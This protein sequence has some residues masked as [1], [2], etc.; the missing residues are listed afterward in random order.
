MSLPSGASVAASLHGEVVDF[1][2]GEPIPRATIRVLG[3]NEAMLSNDSG[4]FKLRLDPGEHQIK[5]SHVAYY[6]E[7]VTV[8]SADSVTGYTIALRPALIEV[9]GTR[10][11]D[12]EVDPAGAI[13]LEAIRRKKDLLSQLDSYSF[14]AYTKLVVWRTTTET[15]VDS[16]G[17]ERTEDSSRIILLAET[18]ATSWWKQPDKF[19]QEIIAR[20]QSANLEAEQNFATVR[21]ILNFNANRIDILRYS[22]PTPTATDALD[23][24]NYYLLDTVMID[25]M[26]AF[27]L[28]V[29]PRDPVRPRFAGTIDIADSSYAVVGVDLGFSDGVDIQYL[30]DAGYRQRMAL[31]ENA[32]WMPVEVQFYGHV[33]ITAPLFGE[34][35][36]DIKQEALI[37][38]YRF[39]PELPD[40]LFDEFVLEVDA[41]ADDADSAR[42][43]SLPR[44]DLTAEETY[45]YQRIDSLE[46]APKPI[47]Y[48]ARLVPV[49]ILAIANSSATY[50]FVHFNRVEGPYLGAGFDFRLGERFLFDVASGWAFDGE[51]WQHDYGVRHTLSERERLHVM[52]R[53]RDRVTTMPTA[54]S[55]SDLNPTFGA[56]LSA[57]DPFDYFRAV[58]FTVGFGFAPTSH[59]MLQVSL[60]DELHYSTPIAT[61]FSL[62]GESA[63]VRTNPV[64]EEG[65]LRAMTAELTFDSRNRLKSGHRE[66]VLQDWPN[67]QFTIGVEHASDALL[68]QE[69]DFTRYWIRLEH[70][71]RLFGLGLTSLYAYFSAAADP[72][73]PQRLTTVD[74]AYDF[75][76][77]QHHFMTL[78]R[79]GFA[80]DHVYAFQIEHDFERLLF[81][82]SGIP[83][84]RES[85]FSLFVFGGMFWT[86]FRETTLRSGDHRQA[87]NKPYSEIGFGIGRLPMFLSVMF[88]FQLSSYNTNNFSW[89]I[90]ARF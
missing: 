24:Y 31:F 67:T 42:W 12:R 15:I 73:P 60:A 11:Y 46:S 10:V 71:R 4:R 69:F 41:G 89:D 63:D 5:V 55:P 64:I 33:E 23:H 85:P 22:I 86:E 27:R 54:V 82:R 74:P 34:F 32:Y 25:S 49:S 37:Y 13:I 51:Y 40:G 88:T 62:F 87:A 8:T 68:A 2:T 16:T 48:Y 35:S 65:R 7:T 70:E 58:G 61:D 52:A 36:L 39:D 3:T 53:Y 43:D 76:D 84:L 56:A 66:E 21:D 45:G 28:E 57:I 75:F 47:W 30:S 44:I 80:G 78:D 38:N 72:L 26:A 19:K 9:R 17:V 14:D 77:V 1:E 29:E 50:D 6:S 90:A 81:R 79:T 59:S 83:L 20:R 18:Q